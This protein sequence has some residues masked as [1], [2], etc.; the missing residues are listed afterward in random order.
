MSVEQ[1]S[2]A[3]LRSARDEI[4]EDAPIA[5]NRMLAYLGPVMSWAAQEDLIEVNSAPSRDGGRR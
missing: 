4:A 1:F 3:D 2:K 5:A